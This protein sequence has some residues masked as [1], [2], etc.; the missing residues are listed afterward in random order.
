MIHLIERD[1][2]QLFNVDYNDTTLIEDVQVY[3]PRDGKNKYKLPLNFNIDDLDQFCLYV[4]NTDSDAVTPA[5]LANAK[6]LFE[7]LDNRPYNNNDALKAR[8]EYINLALEAR[9]DLALNTKPNIRTYVLRNCNSKLKDILE[10]EIIEYISHNKI[11]E[12]TCKYINT[13]VFDSLMDGWSLVC[14]KKLAKII[15]RKDN[16]GYA[17]ISDFTNDFKN[18]VSDM[19]NQLTKSERFIREGKGFDLSSKTIRDEIRGVTKEL[20]APTNRLSTG[21]QYLNKMLNGG[22]ESGRSYIFMGLPGIGK[23]IIL[24]SIAMWM[25]MYNKLPKVEDMR[26]AVL[27]ISQ[28]N[29]KT[30]TF[31]RMFN[32]CV[33]GEDLKDVDDAYIENAMKKAGLIVDENDDN[34]INFIFKYFNDKEIGCDDIDAMISDYQRK[35]VQIIAV[36]QDYVEKLKPKNDYGEM[37][38]NLGSVV[39]EM[40]EL[41]KRHK[42]PFVSAAQLNRTAQSVTDSAI[43]NNKLNTI[44][45]LGKQNISESWDKL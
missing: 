20:N 2:K 1:I 42:I 44:K 33:S 26:Q 35:G 21:I 22:L 40:S 32:I 6:T 3:D 30:E 4:S 24:L 8:L 37:R 14:S 17:R 13:L 12:Y 16:S 38:F 31:E 36:V 10:K 34:S 45:L 29:S 15:D 23:S 9:I 39:I 18:I 7:M 25:K 11:T 41:A 5:A 27:F 19:N 28:E 43:A